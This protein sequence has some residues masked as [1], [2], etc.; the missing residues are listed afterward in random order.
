MGIIGF[1]M[2]VK[3][4]TKIVECGLMA[5]RQSEKLIVGAKQ[6][7][8]GLNAGKVLQVYLAENADPAI[9]EPLEARCQ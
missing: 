5:E 3:K 6:I 2:D 8:K 4:D 7:R 1:C 9:T